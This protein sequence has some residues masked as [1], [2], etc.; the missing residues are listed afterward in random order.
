LLLFAKLEEEGQQ[1]VHTQDADFSGDAEA[2]ER[3][4]PPPKSVKKKKAPPKDRK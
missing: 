2:H 4:T 3:P 1:K